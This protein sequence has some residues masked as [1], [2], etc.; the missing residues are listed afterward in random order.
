MKQVFAM[1]CFWQPEKLSLAVTFFLRSELRDWK[2]KPFILIDT[3]DTICNHPTSKALFG[4]SSSQVHS[5]W[6]ADA[7][8]L[9]VCDLNANHVYHFSVACRCHVGN[10]TI[11]CEVTITLISYHT[12]CFIFCFFMGN[13]LFHVI[14][15]IFRVP[16]FRVWIVVRNWKSRDRLIIF[17]LPH[18][19]YKECLV[20]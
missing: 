15:P 20:L 18:I 5:S 6:S 19:L 2:Q 3:T 1:F 11:S 12:V 4:N 10:P 16:I 17:Q 7:R 8:T 9:P 14:I 13:Y